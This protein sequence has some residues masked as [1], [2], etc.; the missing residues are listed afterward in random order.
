MSGPAID[1]DKTY[2]K[3]KCYE[4]EIKLLPDAETE[5]KEILKKRVNYYNAKIKIAKSNKNKGEKAE[6]LLL[7]RLHYLNELEQFDK[8]IDIFGEE[9]SEGISILDLATD[10]EILDVNRFSKASSSYKADCKIKMKKTK[11][12]YSISI[13]SKHGASPAILNHTNRKAKIFQEGGILYDY[14]PY[15]DTILQE[16][17]Y[18]R[19]N[20]IICED[21][22]VT[23]L[24]CL[25]DDNSLREKFIEVLTYFV[26]NGSGKGYSK[27]SANAIITYDD[28]ITFMRCNCIQDKKTYIESIYDKIV[29]S[30][31]HKGM[32]KL[33]PEY[34]KPWIFDNIESDNSVK[35][36]GGLHIRI[37]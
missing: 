13:K 10:E 16:Y 33:I 30:L 15:L 22:P 11:S 12:V 3:I 32:P 29:I 36:K 20:K 4:A 28:K 21:V 24:T 25:E 2:N 5:R 37:K 8:L 7:L 1:V 34:C 26:F 27:C 31:R 6:V 17:I 9:A 19:V 14:L 23:S 18:K 35:H